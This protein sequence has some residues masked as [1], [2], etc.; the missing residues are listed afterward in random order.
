MAGSARETSGSGFQDTDRSGCR[1][2]QRYVYIDVR[3]GRRGFLRVVAAKY[4]PL[5]RRQS[6][7]LLYGA[8]RGSDRQALG[9]A[10][11]QQQHRDQYDPDAYRDRAWRL[12][13]LRHRSLRRPGKPDATIHADAARDIFLRDRHGLHADRNIA[14]AALDGV[15]WTPG[16]RTER[17]TFHNSSVRRDR[18][19][20]GW[21]ALS[22]AAGGRR[23]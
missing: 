4:Q 23:E 13:V 20:H 12:R 1:L 7:L 5:D 3:Q 10:F 16:L 18:Q 22:P 11:V 2:R 21:Y 19:H 8:F 17:D 9:D 6:V 15:P 14:D